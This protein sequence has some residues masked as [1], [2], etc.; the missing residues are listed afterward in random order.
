MASVGAG[1]R[2]KGASGER[3]IA[4]ILTEYGYP[5]HRG[6]FAAGEPDVVGLPGVHIEVKRR[7]KLA[8]EDWMSQAKR[9][10]KP[11]EMPAV[12]HRKNRGEW[13]V[14]VPLDV[15]MTIYREWEAGCRHE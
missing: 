3:E 14:S 5:C 11:R 12:F 2:R 13:L 9:D 10:A 4:A 8:L 6:I 7:E 1:S 15:F